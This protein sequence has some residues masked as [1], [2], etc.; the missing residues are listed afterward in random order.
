MS[1]FENYLKKFDITSTLTDEDIENTL[2]LLQIY[3]PT[4][5]RTADR[6]EEMD[7]EC[8]EGRRQS[9]SDFIMNAALNSVN[10]ALKKLRSLLKDW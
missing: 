8:Y 10:G 9:I 3:S 6:I 2:A 5:R 4:V 7:E 1:K